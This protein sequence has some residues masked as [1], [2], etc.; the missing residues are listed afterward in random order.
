VEWFLGANRMFLPFQSIGPLLAMVRWSETQSLS[1]IMLALNMAYYALREIRTPALIRFEMKIT[2]A[3]AQCG[4]IREILASFRPP[5]AASPP[6]EERQFYLKQSGHDATLNRHERNIAGLEDPYKANMAE[7]EGRLRYLSL[8][9][10]AVMMSLLIYSTLHASHSLREQW[11]WVFVGIGL[12]PIATFVW[13]NV[14]ILK[15]LRVTSD[16]LAT[17]YTEVMNLHNEITTMDVPS[18]NK[19][20]RRRSQETAGDVDFSNQ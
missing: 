18:Y 19:I 7:W 10:A 14:V 8:S 4:Q 5:S 1:Q 17:I 9:S 6:V 16:H 15:L 13:Y 12:F 3:K 2:K 11:V 20:V